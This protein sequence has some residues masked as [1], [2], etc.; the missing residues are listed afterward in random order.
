MITITARLEPAV[1]DTVI[2][3]IDT[4]VMTS[5]DAPAG[6]SAGQQR[7]DALAG[8]VTGGGANIHAEIL[9]NVHERTDGTISACLTDGTPV[10][11][12]VT[13]G[14]AA[15]ASCCGSLHLARRSTSRRSRPTSPGPSGAVGMCPI[16]PLDD[17]RDPYHVGQARAMTSSAKRLIQSVMASGVIRS[18]VVGV[19]ITRVAPA[20]A[21][22]RTLSRS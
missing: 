5:R 7:A 8:L 12:G 13:A 14:D 10:K 6:A 11:S 2:A 15:R 20:S 16:D 22:R 18:D 17:Q 21:L 4:T 9:V 19:T 1:A 3:A